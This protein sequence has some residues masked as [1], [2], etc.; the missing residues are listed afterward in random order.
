MPST[1]AVVPPACHGTNRVRTVDTGRTPSA[2]QRRPAP[3]GYPQRSPLMGPVRV[4]VRRAHHWKRRR[5]WWPDEG[6][7]CPVRH[8]TGPDHDEV[9]RTDPMMM[10]TKAFWAFER[11]KEGGRGTTA[12]LLLLALS[13]LRHERERRRGGKGGR[14]KGREGRSPLPLPAP[15]PPSS[16]PPSP[17][18]RR[19]S[20]SSCL[21]SLSLLLV[22]SLSQIDQRQSTSSPLFHTKCT[23]FPTFTPVLFSQ[24][25]V[26]K[27]LITE[28]RDR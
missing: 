8:E 22:V 24:E 17:Q 9:R 23:D 21:P 15:L 26:S 13:S 7:P 10:W 11:G 5:V 4:A 12:P 1:R 14:G 27:V 3:D 18:C 20:G 6:R 2:G 25:N 16:R 19:S 28:G